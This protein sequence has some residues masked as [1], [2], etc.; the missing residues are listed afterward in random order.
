LHARAKISKI[1]QHFRYYNG[2]DDGMCAKK[3][4]MEGRELSPDLDKWD[5]HLFT[6]LLLLLS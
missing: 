1:I 4:G 6:L 3:K 5:N 2:S